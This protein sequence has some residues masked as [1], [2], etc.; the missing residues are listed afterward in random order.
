MIMGSQPPK[1]GGGFRKVLKSGGVGC[2]G[3]QASLSFEALFLEL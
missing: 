3:V 2:G 1:K